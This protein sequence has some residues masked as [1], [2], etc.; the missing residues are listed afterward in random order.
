MGSFAPPS[1][2]T[3]DRG[4]SRAIV[5]PATAQSRARTLAE[6]VTRG[7]GNWWEGGACHRVTPPPP[8]VPHD[9]L[10]SRVARDIPRESPIFRRGK[11]HVAANCPPLGFPGGGLLA[12]VR[13]CRGRGGGS[14]VTSPRVSQPPRQEG[15]LRRG[16]G[17]DYDGGGWDGSNGDCRTK[18]TALY[19]HV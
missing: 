5:S 18:S 2:E 14:H 17:N 10:G 15:Q 9:K 12:C 19:H 7:R 1:S 11:G 13:G 8:T 4:R 16:R 6:L 3:W